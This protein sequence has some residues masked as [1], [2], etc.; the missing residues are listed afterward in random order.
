MRDETAA[1]KEESKR[2][3]ELTRTDI[4]ATP[5]PDMTSIGTTD[6]ASLKAESERILQLTR[7][8]STVTNHSDHRDREVALGS[9]ST[10]AINNHDKRSEDRESLVEVGQAKKEGSGKMA[11]DDDESSQDFEESNFRIK[12]EKPCRNLSKEC[13]VGVGVSEDDVHLEKVIAPS[14]P[15]RLTRSTP[16]VRTSQPGAFNVNSSGVIPAQHMDVSDLDHCEHHNIY[17]DVEQGGVSD[18]SS[19]FLL[20]GSSDG[21]AVANLIKEEDSRADRPKAD[22]VDM[23]K[24]E[25]NRQEVLRQKRRSVYTC[26]G[27]MTLVAAV[28]AIIVGLAIGLTIS[29]GSGTSNATTTG[30]TIPSILHPTYA[31]VTPAERVR[32]LLPSYTLQQIQWIGSP[33]QQ[34][35]DW[36]MDDSHLDA[37]SEE[38]IVQRYALA[39]FYFA[40][41]GDYWFNQ[42]RWLSHDHHECD[43]FSRNSTGIFYEPE[44]NRYLQ[45]DITGGP[46]G[47][48]YVK[49]EPRYRIDQEE[50]STYLHIWLYSNNIKGEIPAEVSLLSSLQSLSLDRNELQGELT[51]HIGLLQNLEAIS[52]YTN[53]LSGHIPTEIGNLSKLTH[54]WAMKNN[55][56][57][58]FPTELG[59]NSNLRQLLLDS[60]KMTGSLP[61]ELGH[62]SS[63]EWMWIHRADWTGTVPTEMGLMT[64]LEWLDL[65]YTMLSG[66]IPTEI[67]LLD[68]VKIL[69]LEHNGWLTGTIP[70]EIGLMT[71][72]N[73][74]HFHNGNWT[75]SIPSQIGQL[76]DMIQLF[77]WVNQLTGTLPTEL[78]LLSPKRFDVGLDGL[79]GVISSDGL[80][81]SLDESHLTGTIPSELGLSK[82]LALLHLI[83]NKLTGKIPSELGQLEDFT[84]SLR[85]NLNQ[86]TGT[87][88][89]EIG[90]LR[91]W[92]L[93]LSNNMF[94]ASLPS[95]FAL[96]TRL[97]R[98]L[99]DSNN[100]T[101]TIPLELGTLPNLKEV[102][103]SG[104][105]GLVGSIPMSMCELNNWTIEIVLDC[106]TM[107]CSCD[108]CSCT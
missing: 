47:Q 43:W 88:P 52:L 108:A 26:V 13:A 37:F 94:T 12:H 91:P 14:P 71:S 31:P 15:A 78:G 57:G 45:W 56:V 46:C 69:M 66:A 6:P 27:I 53:S 58:N 80:Q 103:I 25:Q 51:T 77:G 8:D 33:Q 42:N 36:L 28:T 87:I 81:I 64:N 107:E 68:Q 105:A 11:G 18:T 21:I 10:S 1:L 49:N 2:I 84:E 97:E 86:L 54:I 48:S 38:R 35:Y 63:L 67:G 79:D 93:Q 90:N 104:N 83:G 101:G 50:N 85:L 60:T 72:M 70:S 32:S 62:L 39:V 7:P 22:Y 74:F 40:T 44:N 23:K 73:Y 99:L 98:L 75:G 20:S 76:R 89:S 102:N 4:E 3:L 41:S 95:E 17:L 82:S 59:R 65:S 16:M 24:I 29:A 30:T 96:I 9:T 92:R 34:A 100:L 61:T 55:F 5:N 19:T 106:D